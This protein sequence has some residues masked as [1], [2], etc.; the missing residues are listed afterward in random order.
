LLLNIRIFKDNGV[1]IIL[2][3]RNIL[4]LCSRKLQM[5]HTCKLFSKCLKEDE[6]LEKCNDPECQNVIH[7]GSFK[8]LVATFGEN[9]REGPLFCSMRCF[10][11]HKKAIEA[12]ASKAKGRVLWDNE[13]PMPIMNSIAV[14]IDW[15]TASGNYKQ[16]LGGNKQ[17]GTTKLGITNEKCQII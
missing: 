2:E 15:L 14:M 6:S 7:L 8:N 5:D 11:N 4:A 17:N 3:V 16:R 13:G 1:L 12:V 10:K 9:K